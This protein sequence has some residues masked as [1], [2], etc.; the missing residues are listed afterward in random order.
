VSRI[1]TR[2][3]CAS[4]SHFRKAG[5]APRTRCSSRGRAR[6]RV[7]ASVDARATRP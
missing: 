1:S 3:T 6:H 5:I 2:T 4:R 7:A